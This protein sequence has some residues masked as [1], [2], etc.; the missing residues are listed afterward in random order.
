MSELRPKRGA[1]GIGN[2]AETRPAEPAEVAPAFA[3]ET[4]RTAVSLETAATAEP[5]AES[6]P[7]ATG[8]SKKATASVDDLWVDPWAV[9]TESQTAL[10]RGFEAVATEVTGMARSGLTVATEAA[11]AMLGAKTFAEAIEINAGFARRSFDA[12]IGGTAKL[13]EIGVKA[14][15]DASR[16]LLNRLGESWNGWSNH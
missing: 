5:I 12:V 13:S 4:A 7:A 16:P 1:R 15:T 11:Q 3:A 9:W 6:S 8:P 2:R 10:T 14:A